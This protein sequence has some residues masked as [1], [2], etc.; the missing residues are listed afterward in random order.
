MVNGSTKCAGVLAETPY[1]KPPNLRS[2]LQR[3]LFFETTR[4]L[5]LFRR[6]SD[7]KQSDRTNIIVNVPKQ[8][9]LLQMVR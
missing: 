8:Y 9:H 5:G 2:N 4:P 6:I 7:F 3:P 1:E